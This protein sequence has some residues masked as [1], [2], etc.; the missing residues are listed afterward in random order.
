MMEYNEE[1]NEESDLN[2]SFQPNTNFLTFQE[3]EEDLYN[4]NLE[5]ETKDKRSE[6][7]L[8]ED[9]TN[10]LRKF[11]IFQRYIHMID[12]EADLETNTQAE[13]LLGSFHH[14]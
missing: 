1:N 11:M 12:P 4:F 8:A 6:W 10:Y 13:V 3:I 2:F 9:Y 5:Y 7:A 14:Y